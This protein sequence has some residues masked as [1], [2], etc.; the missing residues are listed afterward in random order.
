MSASQAA[1]DYKVA[2]NLVRACEADL[3][4]AKR[5]R[6]AAAEEVIDTFSDEGVLSVKAGPAGF[7]YTI[8]VRIDNWPTYPQGSQEAYC[9]VRDQPGLWD[10]LQKPAIN[11]SSLRSAWLAERFGNGPLF[12]HEG[13]VDEQ[14]RL[15][16]TFPATTSVR[17]LGTRKGA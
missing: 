12:T 13:I 16:V 11:R 17:L 5:S 8:S 1:M 14:G 7:E 3:K 15:I 2:D 10:C 4:D 6:E 9:F